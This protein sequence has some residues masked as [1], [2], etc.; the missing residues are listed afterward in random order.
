[1]QE[2]LAA[3][4]YRDEKENSNKEKGEISG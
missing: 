2:L 1:M 4:Q 3:K